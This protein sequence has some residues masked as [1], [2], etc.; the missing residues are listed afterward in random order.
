M[1]FITGRQP[2]CLREVTTSVGC[3]CSLKVR[4]PYSGIYPAVSEGYVAA[5]DRVVFSLT[6]A[7]FHFELNKMHGCTFTLSA[8]KKTLCV[9]VAF[10]K[11]IEYLNHNFDQI[12]VG[13]GKKENLYKI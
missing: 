11:S 5:V 13:N 1:K 7:V 2:Y 12:F 10:D 8:S 3:T 4:L 6:R 9:L